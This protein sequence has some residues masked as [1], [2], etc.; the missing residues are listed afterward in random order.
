MSNDDP[1]RAT[2]VVSPL[3]SRRPDRSRGAMSVEG[4]ETLRETLECGE[5]GVPTPWG[6]PVLSG[7]AGWG[8]FLSVLVSESTSACED[9]KIQARTAR[10]ILF[11]G[12]DQNLDK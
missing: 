9:R 3:G 2:P 6:L 10:E 11:L 7:R 8:S 5:A 12:K 1:S 4:A